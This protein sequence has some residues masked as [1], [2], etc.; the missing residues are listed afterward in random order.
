MSKKIKTIASHIGKAA[1]RFGIDDHWRIHVIPAKKK[2]LRKNVYMLCTPD[3]AY[4]NASILIGNMP[5]SEIKVSC[6]HEAAH[7]ALCEMTELAEKIAHEKRKSARRALWIEYRSAVE[8]TCQRMA[9]AAENEE[10]A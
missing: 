9:R 5:E 3:S 2:E 10:G 4:F 7:I 1:R 6:Y 8:R